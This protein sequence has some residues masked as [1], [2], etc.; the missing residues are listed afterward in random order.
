MA[1]A[2]AK[3]D[4]KKY[5]DYKITGV[6]QLDTARFAQSGESRLVLGDIQDGTGFRRARLA[7]VGNVS[8]RGSYMLEFDLPQGQVDL[9]MGN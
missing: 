1:A 9:S 4:E 2:A 7:A 3:P 5:P 6:F 8:E